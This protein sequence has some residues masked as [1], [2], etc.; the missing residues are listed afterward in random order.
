ML[1]RKRFGFNCR[2]Y[3]LC[4]G[5][6]VLK[7]TNLDACLIRVS[8]L[9]LSMFSKLL[10]KDLESLKFTHL[11]D[12]L[13]LFVASLSTLYML[14]YVPISITHVNALALAFALAHSLFHQSRC[15]FVCYEHYKI[16]SSVSTD[17]HCRNEGV[18]L[19]AV[20]IMCQQII[21]ESKCA[22]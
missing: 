2:T 5:M 19:L 21:W 15:I 10:V 8:H 14:Y 16:Y 6:C 12:T 20:H 3:I 11:I 18:A 13:S 7:S 22:K 4:V 1:F 9:G 17:K